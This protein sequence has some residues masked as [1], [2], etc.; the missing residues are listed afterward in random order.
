MKLRVIATL[1][2][3][4]GVAAAASAQTIGVYWDRM[5]QFSVTHLRA[6]GRMSF[7]AN[8]DRARSRRR[9]GASSV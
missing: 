5:E 4:L 1:V 2:L 8:A 9:T 3:A 7:L 6:C